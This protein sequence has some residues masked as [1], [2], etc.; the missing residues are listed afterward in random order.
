MVS[1]GGERARP[2]S[3]AAAFRAASLSL[4]MPDGDVG[5]GVDSSASVSDR[6]MG[7]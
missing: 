7:E 3:L 5:F 2:V 6:T 4:S 1:L